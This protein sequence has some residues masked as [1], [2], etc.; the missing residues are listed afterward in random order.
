MVKIIEVYMK[1]I[2]KKIKTNK[3]IVFAESKKST[4]ICIKQIKYGAKIQNHNFLWNYF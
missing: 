2:S 3:Q 1:A 4:K